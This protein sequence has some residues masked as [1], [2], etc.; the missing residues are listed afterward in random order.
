MK[1]KFIIG[2]IY[3]AGTA[4]AVYAVSLIEPRAVIALAVLALWAVGI[5]VN[6]YAIRKTK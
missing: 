1:D 4:A 2:G 3:F 5:L 6:Q